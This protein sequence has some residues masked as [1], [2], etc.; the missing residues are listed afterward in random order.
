MKGYRMVLTGLFVAA[1]FAS[2]IAFGQEAQSTSQAKNLS[3]QVVSVDAAKNVISIK[4]DA[5]MDKSI[6]VAASTKITRAGK[7]ILL[8]DIQAGDRLIYILD[9]T[10]E[11]APVKSISVM[12]AKE[13]KP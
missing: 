5:G 10:G 12:P 8:A 1:L 13:T 9:D 2:A 3:G 6:N 4:D 7:D 11:S